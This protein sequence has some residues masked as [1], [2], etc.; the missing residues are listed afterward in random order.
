MH[1][2]VMR[3]VDAKRAGRLW[4]WQA[5]L[6]HVKAR[7]FHRRCFISPAR[8]RSLLHTFHKGSGGGRTRRDDDCRSFELA[9]IRRPHTIDRAGYIARDRFSLGFTLD[10]YARAQGGGMQAVDERLPSSVEV[11]DALV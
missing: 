10:H 4:S 2:Q 1:S 9:A 3:A 7:R 11:Q 6:R 5:A 8:E